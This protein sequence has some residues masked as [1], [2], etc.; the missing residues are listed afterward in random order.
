MYL[1]QT[2]TSDTC[3][4]SIHVFKEGLPPY[5]QLGQA[6]QGDLFAESHTTTNRW[7]KYI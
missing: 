7:K 4:R 6:R 3:N 2:G 5:N 1:Q